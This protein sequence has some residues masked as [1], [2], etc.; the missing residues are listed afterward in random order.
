MDRGILRVSYSD[1][2]RIVLCYRFCCYGMGYVRPVIQVV[3][4]TLQIHYCISSTTYTI[5]IYIV[6]ISNENYRIL[7]IIGNYL[8]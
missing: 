8:K 6:I 5:T 1:T 3:T 4:I 7:E 2:M